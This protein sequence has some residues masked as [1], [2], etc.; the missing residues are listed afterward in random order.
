MEIT[1]NTKAIT[2]TTSALI[3][4]IIVLAAGFAGTAFYYRGTQAQTTPSTPSV[5]TPGFVSSSTYVAESGNQFQWLDPA[6]SYYQYDY[7]ILDNQYEKL[8]WYNGNSTTQVIPWLAENYTQLS[9]TR[10]QFQLRQGITFQDGTPFNAQAVWFSLNRLLII[11]GTSGTGD[12]GTQAAWIVEQMLNQSLFSYFGT[13]PKY[14]PAWVQSVLNQNFVQVVDPYTININIEHPT[15]QFPYI[16]AGEWA[17]IVS[18]SFVVSHDFPSACSTPACSPDT[19]NY[20]SY[21]DHIAGHGEVSMNYLNLPVNGSKAGTGPYYIESVNPTTYQVVMKANPNYWGGPKSW[22]GPQINVAIKTLDFRYVPD[23]TTR[24]LDARAGKATEIAVSSSDIYS[25]ASRDQWLNNGTLVSIIPGVTLYGPYP[26]F[27]TDWFNFVTNA[28]DAAG[29]IEKF[30]PFADIRFR[31]AVADSLN[32]TDANINLNNNLGEIANNLI[33]PGT[34]PNGAYN[35]DIKPIYSFNLTEVKALLTDAQKHPLT[36]FVDVN[37]HPYPAGTIDNS[38]SQTDPQTIP[39]YVGQADTLD[40]RILAEMT[41]NLNTISTSMGLTFTVVPVPGGQYY[42]LAS[43][44]RI[45]FYWG[46]WVADYNHLLDWLGPMFLSTGSYPAWNNMNYTALNNLYND[47]LNADKNG[48]V[49]RLIQDNNQMETIANNAVMYMYLFYPLTYTVR[50]SFLRG[51]Y[52]NE[53]TA[54]YYY[55]TCYYTTAT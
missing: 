23:L 24:I 3:A 12:H 38:F 41:S 36:H 30:Q 9:P 44:H 43:E 5:P 17:D 54:V 15:T 31:L 35:P 16:L 47:A 28:T 52:Y 51:V 21:F 10:Y 55:A 48:N 29:N 37:G 6:V 33:P 49:Q 18:P 8:L 40:Q 2:R 25:V 39:M 1:M 50:S 13:T 53:A 14:D 7:Q 11:D 42:T 20:T 22:N 34:A 19:I 45:Y 26:Q 27:S 46:G 4:I 32:L